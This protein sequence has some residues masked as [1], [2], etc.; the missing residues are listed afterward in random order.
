[1]TATIS[2]YRRIFDPMQSGE[3]LRAIGEA[4]YGEDWRRAMLDMLGVGERP[5]R[6]WLAGEE[7]PAGVWNDLLAAI[8]NQEHELKKVREQL[9]GHACP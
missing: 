3:L 4:L 9:I 5:F 2:A 1:M 8:R 7:P 6:R